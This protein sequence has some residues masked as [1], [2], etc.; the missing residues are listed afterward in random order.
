MD[1][2]MSTPLFFCGNINGFS[3]FK[4]HDMKLCVVFDDLH[5]A[6]VKYYPADE[7]N[8]RGT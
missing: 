8:L 5:V 1:K 3:D 6:N 7:I 2:A 4:K